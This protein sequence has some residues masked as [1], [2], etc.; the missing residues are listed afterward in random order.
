MYLGKV[1]G[2]VVSTSKNESLAGTKLLLVARL[3]EQLK[4]AGGTEIAVDS[5]GAGNGE[6]VIVTSGSSARRVLGKDASVIDA[7]IVGIVDT[8]QAVS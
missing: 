1:I 2:T 3:T 8:V 7:A 4:P 5:V 6:I